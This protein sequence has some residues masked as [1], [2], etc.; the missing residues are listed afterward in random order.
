MP[1]TTAKVTNIFFDDL[2]TLQHYFDDQINF[3]TVYIVSYTKVQI[4][5]ARLIFWQLFL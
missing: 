3:L 5:I 4:P 1:I 2:I